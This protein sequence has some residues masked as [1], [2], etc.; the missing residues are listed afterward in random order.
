MA[1]RIQL[2]RDTKA[3]WESYN[4]ILLE[5]EPGHV[6]DYPN[7]YKMGDGVHAWNDLPY[8]GYDG[9]VT[10]D[11]QNDE[12][13]V[14]SNAAVSKGLSLIHPSIFTLMGGVD[15]IEITRGKCIKLNGTT[16]DV[17][18]ADYINGGYALVPCQYGDV[19]TIVNA[20]R[21]AN[22]TYRIYGFIDTPNE[23]GIANVI[24]A[25]GSSGTSVTNTRVYAREGSAYAVFNVDLNNPFL[26]Y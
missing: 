16:C 3:N 14:P 7:L 23:S 26:I 15:E 9:T 13:T 2:R 1:D 19:F 8:R 17:N 21:T 18:G 12:N 25:F 10:Q 20:K 6:L 5:G 4:P 11:I 22:T 24:Y